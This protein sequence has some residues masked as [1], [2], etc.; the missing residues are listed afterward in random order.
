[1]FGR[2]SV[3][4]RSHGFWFWT[5]LIFVFLGDLWVLAVD[6]ELL[7]DMVLFAL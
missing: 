1:L 3:F 4:N 5:S 2:I 7:S 6:A